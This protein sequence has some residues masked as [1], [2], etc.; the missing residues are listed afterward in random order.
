MTTGG[1]G[2]MASEVRGS[3]D[4]GISGAKLV[5]GRGGL[6]TPLIA[7]RF[8]S[9]VAKKPEGPS[10]ILWSMGGMVHRGQ[11][12]RASDLPKRLPGTGY[13]IS[14]RMCRLNQFQWS[15]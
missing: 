8:P 5:A 6:H 13:A 3:G 11:Q 15:R 7:S 2:L 1:R 10:E 4:T 9:Y 14:P 12:S